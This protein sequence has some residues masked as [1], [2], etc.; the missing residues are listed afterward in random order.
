MII[1]LLMGYTAELLHPLDVRR[2]LATMGDSTTGILRPSLGV[3]GG[4]SLWR[5]LRVER[6]IV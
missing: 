1:D 5:Y 3:G 2:V 4:R 6:W